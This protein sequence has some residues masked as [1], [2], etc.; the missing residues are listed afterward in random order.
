[1]GQ[2][3]T[4]GQPLVSPAAEC[5]GRPGRTRG[6]ETSQYPEERKSTETPSVAASERG[7]AHG[8]EPYVMVSGAEGSG[9]G[10]HRR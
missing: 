6:T 2:P 10:H 3:G 4:T 9:K 8:L 1:M 7:L 5:I